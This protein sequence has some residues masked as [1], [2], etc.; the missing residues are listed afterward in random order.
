MVAD[1]ESLPTA[2]DSTLV[3]T[4]LRTI[5]RRKPLTVDHTDSVFII[6]LMFIRFIEIPRAAILAAGIGGLGAKRAPALPAGPLRVGQRA[7]GELRRRPG[8]GAGDGRGGGS[9]RGPGARRGAPAAHPGGLI[10][11]TRAGPTLR[12][13]RRPGA[14]LAAHDAEPGHRRVA[15][16]GAD[17]RA[18]PRRGLHRPGELR[19]R[20]RPAGEPRQ[21]QA[22]RRC[23]ARFRARVRRQRG[24]PQA[25]RRDRARRPRRADSVY[26][27]TDLDR[28][29]ESI[30][31]HVV[32][33]ADIPEDKT[34]P[35]DVQRDHPQ[36]DH[37]GLPTSR[38]T[39][40]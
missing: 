4:N 15:G 22:G 12:S 30:A 24:P 3:C 29:G 6:P 13:A 25:G 38:A 5:E 39:S 35:G 37:R 27:A 32:E 14:T 1:I 10:T 28:E 34:P 18:V 9:V 11:L 33:A 21:R 17:D 19:A 7:D 2:D 20:P 31:W 26:L 16:E 8:R 23:R 36:R 40:T